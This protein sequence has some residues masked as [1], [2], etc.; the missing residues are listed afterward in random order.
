[1]EPLMLFSA[2]CLV[3][4]AAVSF[5]DKAPAL[6]KEITPYPVV[7]NIEF[8]EGPIF[9]SLGNLYFVNYVRNGTL[10]KMTPDGTLT[11]WCETGGQ[12][13]GLKV[14][15]E[16]YIIGADTGAKRVIRVH[17]DGKRIEVLTDRYEGKPY[18][19]PNDVCLD[20]AGNIYFSDP[21]NETPEA[22]IGGVYRIERNKKV[23]RLIDGL[24][25][26]NGLAVSPDQKQ[27]LV[28]ETMT[29]RIL[30]YALN[31][32]GSLGPQKTLYQF[33]NSS[34]DGIMFDEYD[35]LWVARW[36]NGTVAVITLD[37]K[38]VAEIAAGGTKVTNLCFWG[39]SVYVTVAGN[40][41]IHRLEVGVG[42][43]PYTR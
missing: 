13:N 28:A 18:H 21:S 5:E 1:M 41:S 12:V 17:P 20:M 39:K 10:G 24:K 8:A 2:I 36:L 23:T 15:S 7:A 27:L 14:D 25:Y 40:H 30:A 33:P 11:V 16:G 6:P 9:D 38:L 43:K 4:F 34:V 29:N 22:P 3:L 42:G 19:S 37:G 26:P 31:P 35:R 32:D